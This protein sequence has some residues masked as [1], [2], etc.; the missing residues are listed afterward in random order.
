MIFVGTAFGNNDRRIDK[1]YSANMNWLD[2]MAW[3]SWK[4]TIIVIASVLVIWAALFVFVIL[5]SPDSSWVGPEPKTTWG[6]F[7]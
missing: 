5:V 2:D 6:E 1:W 3:W 7:F 4:K